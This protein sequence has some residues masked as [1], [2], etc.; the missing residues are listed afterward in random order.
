[1]RQLKERAKKIVT[2]PS[3]GKVTDR[4]WMVFCDYRDTLMSADD[5]S[6]FWELSRS[7]IQN[8]LHKVMKHNTSVLNS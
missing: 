4:D 6:D 1:M 3:T 7:Q 2:R 8:I 5:L